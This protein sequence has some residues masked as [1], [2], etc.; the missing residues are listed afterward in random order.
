M[1]RP[2]ALALA[3]VL[4]T[5]LSAMAFAG[6]VAARLPVVVYDGPSDSTTPRY[7]L[8]KD[9]PL[10]VISETTGWLT[11]CMHDG[12]SGHIHRGDARPGDTVVVLYSSV[13][14]EEPSQAANPVLNAGAQLLLANTGDV[15]SGWLPVRHESGVSGFIRASDVWGHSGC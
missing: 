11:I 1:K 12:T 3:A 6:K 8:G 2:G 7:L 10:V 14:R 4:L 13:V 5:A 15:I 9:Y